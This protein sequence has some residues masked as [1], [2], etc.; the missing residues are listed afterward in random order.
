M[1]RRK[2]TGEVIDPSWTRYAFPPLWHYDVLRALDYLRSAGVRANARLDEAVAIV[3]ERQ[4]ADGRWLLDVRH[5]NTLHEDFAG[6]VGAPNRWITL[7]ARRVIDWS[8]A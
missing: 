5:P 7:R 2:S 1:L 8:Q 6:V 4:Q 3:R